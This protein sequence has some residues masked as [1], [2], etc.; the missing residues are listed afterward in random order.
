[1]LGDINKYFHNDNNPYA[2]QQLIGFK[3]LFKGVIA[4]EWIV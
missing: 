3:D 1:M 2:N 4:K